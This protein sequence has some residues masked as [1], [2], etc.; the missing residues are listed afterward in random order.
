[1]RQILQNLKTGE[2]ELAE[3]PCPEVKPNHLLIRTTRSLISTGTERMVIEFSRA[4]LVAKATQQP[5]RLRAVIE[6]L[7][8][9][10]VKPTI[11]AL[12]RKL[13]Q[14]LMLGYCNVG[15]IVELGANVTGFAIGDRVACNGSHAEVVSVPVNLC[16]RIPDAVSDEEAAF[17][18]LAA[19]ALQGIRLAQ[20]TFGESV[21]VIGLGLIG[22]LTVQ[23]LRATGCRVLAV[24]VDESR[25]ELA[26]G[27]GAETV[28]ALAG[29]NPLV[30]AERFSYGHGVDA[31]IVTA[32]TKSN[33]PIYQAA[34]MCR[35][36]GRIVLV[37]VTGLNLS[38][39]QLYRKELTL[40]VS[41]SYGPGRY[42]PFYEEDGHDYPIGYV[43]WTEQRNFEAVLDAMATGKLRVDALISHRFALK[44]S[45]KAYELISGSQPSLGV[46]LEYPT[47]EAPEELRSRRITLV[48]NREASGAPS[49]GTAFIGAGS[50][51]TSVL[52]PKFKS[53]GARLV[54]VVSSGGTTAAY[55]GRKYGFRVASTDATAVLN[56]PAVDAVVIATRHDSHAQLVLNALEARKHVFVEKPMCLT[57]DELNRIESMYS[58]MLATTGCP[59][60]MVGFNRRF[61]PHVRRLKSLL[62]SVTAPKAFVMTVNAGLVPSEH[63]THNRVTGGGRV[64][65]EAC[66]FIDLLRFLADSRILAHDRLVLDTATRDSQTMHLRFADGSIGTIHYFANGSRAFPKERLEIFVGGAVLQ[67]DNFKTLRAYGWPGF[68]RM[69][70]W[71]Q[72]KGQAA[73]AEAFLKTIHSG[74][75][76]PIPFDHIIEVSRVAIALGS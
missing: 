26:R 65:G 59:V 19:I 21:V 2:T 62:T 46:I 41:C 38:R 24:D 13:D 7:G 51:A 14:P 60:L 28:N 50:Y 76:S 48:G 31:A 57:L 3:V 4:G 40:Q 9:D 70:L 32:A 58:G 45:R 34:S 16:A 17:T 66:H 75:P 12:A 29:Q 42:D 6:K 56:D 47:S 22:Q 27:L 67:L 35:K 8:T 15:I 72:D 61:A 36:R 55:A 49:P 52:I 10:G 68:N 5:Q 74:L 43:R 23:L 20:P 18:P 11:E 44:D 69:K 63:W 25:L 73:C 39:E 33:E 37:G 53:A 30:T 64:I 1:M 54:T 71:S